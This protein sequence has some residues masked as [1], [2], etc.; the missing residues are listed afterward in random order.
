MWI[1][2]QEVRYI[3]GDKWVFNFELGYWLGRFLSFIR[4]RFSAS[5]FKIDN[6]K[7][8]F[9]SKKAL[10][11]SRKFF[12]LEKHFSFLLRGKLYGPKYM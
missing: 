3:L 10:N 6:L 12:L 2:M 9:A 4:D 11:I 8:F 5:S 7:W 1:T